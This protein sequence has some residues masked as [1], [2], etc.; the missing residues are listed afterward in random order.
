MRITSSLRAVLAAMTLASGATL[1]VAA[2]D[3]GPYL[4]AAAG[5][6]RYDVDCWNCSAARAS[7]FKLGAGYRFGVFAIEGWWTKYGSLSLGDEVGDYHRR[8]RA[9]GV[10]CAWHLPLGPATQALLRVGGASLHLR[11]RDGASASWAEAT[12]GLG[13]LVD[14][15]PALS[16]EVAWDYT[17]DVLGGSPGHAFTAGLRLHF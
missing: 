14:V 6:T 16:L 13:L 4:L 17:Q 5:S 15:A 3:P 10:S 8:V 9:E 7:T 1:P 12:A 2:A 11:H